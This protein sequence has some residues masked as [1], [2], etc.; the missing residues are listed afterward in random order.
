MAVI[1][2]RIY[3]TPFKPVFQPYRKL[4]ESIDESGLD[5]T[6]LRPDW[7]TDAN[8]LAYELTRKGETEKRHR[9]IPDKYSNLRC[10]NQ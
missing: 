2:V 5:Y 8:E 3:Q 1:S 9:P 6:I 4:T 7:F 10:Q